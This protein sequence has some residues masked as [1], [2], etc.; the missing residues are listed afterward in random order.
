MASEKKISA[1]FAPPNKDY[2]PGE[3]LKRLFEFNFEKDLD[4]KLSLREAD[5]KH[6]Q[7]SHADTTNAPLSAPT[8]NPL[9]NG[10]L[11]ADEKVS[12]G[13]T[14]LSHDP[15]MDLLSDLGREQAFQSNFYP[16]PPDDNEDAGW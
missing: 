16:I 6:H 3:H 11:Q 7:N 2:K 10:T 1:M 9:E 12:D 4:E 14:D 8:S 15:L 13:E 5:D